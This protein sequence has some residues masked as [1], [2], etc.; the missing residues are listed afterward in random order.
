[1]IKF[2]CSKIDAKISLKMSKLEGLKIDPKSGQKSI[3]EGGVRGGQNCPKSTSG[4]PGAKIRI[5]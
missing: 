3:F 4:T 1:M 2:G 5:F